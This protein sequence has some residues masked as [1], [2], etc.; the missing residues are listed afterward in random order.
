VICHGAWL[1]V[2]AGL[3]DGRAL[4]SWPSLRDDIRNAGGQWLDR[5]VVV[6]GNWISS[7]KPGDIP[8][9]GAA[10]RELFA[11]QGGQMPPLAGGNR[12]DRSR[13]R[14][15]DRLIPHQI[16]AVRCSSQARAAPCTCGLRRCRTTT[17]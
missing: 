5:E 13:Q 15:S 2:L 10:M 7:R 3:V 1:L 6:D 8:A 14:S 17:W 4:T 12:F 16:A 11:K 9:F